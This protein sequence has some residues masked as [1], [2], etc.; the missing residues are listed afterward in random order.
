MRGYLFLKWYNTKSI[1]SNTTIFT[2]LQHE[3]KKKTEDIISFFPPFSSTFKIS[4]VYL[5][6]PHHKKEDIIFSVSN[7]SL[8][9]V[10]IYCCDK[11]LWTKIAKKNFIWFLLLN[12]GRF[13]NWAHGKSF[14]AIL[15]LQLFTSGILNS[16]FRNTALKRTFTWLHLRSFR[17]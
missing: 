4:L 7:T 9:R 8:K 10:V 16:R 5:L 14:Y 11:L 17:S 13:I 12:I 15:S 2:L 1:S 3:L 6:V